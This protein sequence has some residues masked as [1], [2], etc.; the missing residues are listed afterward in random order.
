M[1]PLRGRF[2]FVRKE[3]TMPKLTKADL[4]DMILADTRVPSWVRTEYRNMIPAEPELKK[5]EPAKADE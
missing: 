2:Y 4:L 3:E 1:A 5:A